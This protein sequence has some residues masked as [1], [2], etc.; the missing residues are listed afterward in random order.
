MD[1]IKARSV[2]WLPIWILKALF[3]KLI[4]AIAIIKIILRL[5]ILLE[6]ICMLGFSL[7]IVRIRNTLMWSMLGLLMIR[8]FISMRKMYSFGLLDSS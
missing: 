1:A 2:L 4:F 5:F 3:V 8:E 6:V 7:W